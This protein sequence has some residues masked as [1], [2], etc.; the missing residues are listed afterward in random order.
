MTNQTNDQNL[1]IEP[2]YK[3]GW[4]WAI[5][6]IPILTVIAGVTTYF[7]AANQPHSMVK[8]DYF[9]EG[10]AINRS[11]EKQ[12]RA[13]ELEI[14]ASF[15]LDKESNLTIVNLQSNAKLSSEL[16]L[17]FSHPTQSKNDQLVQLQSVSANEYVG[18]MPTLVP[19]DWYIQLSDKE[20][21][22]IL[23]SRWDSKQINKVTVKA[24]DQSR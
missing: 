19:A 23:K 16:S 20:S 21:T 12:N 2:W 4:P 7:I 1:D 3:Q 13:V 6:A 10:L 15:V 5:I 14:I 24:A 17:L 8:D 9:K 22:W 11:I 18:E